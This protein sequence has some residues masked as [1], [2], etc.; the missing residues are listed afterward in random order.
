MIKMI[1]NQSKSAF[2]AIFYVT[3][4]TL[5]VI[6]AGLAYYF[7]IRPNPEAPAWQMFVCVGTIL[8]GLAIG[9]I[10]L[11][12]GLIGKSAKPADTNV[13]AAAPVAPAA[14]TPVQPVPVAPPGVAPVQAAPPANR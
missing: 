2:G 4:G 1:R 5:L 7:F 12:F 6:W 9:F 3:L 11:M 14:Q 10:G 8:S 13:G